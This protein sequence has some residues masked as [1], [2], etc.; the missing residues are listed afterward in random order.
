[1][2]EEPDGIQRKCMAWPFTR[3]IIAKA[4]EG[5]AGG[6]FFAN[7]TLH[8]ILTT[9]CWWPTMKKKVYSYRKQCDICQKIGPKVS[10]VQPMNPFIPTEVFQQ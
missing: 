9:L 10:R 7:H 5:V 2:K 3:A 6:H 1:M 4:H 8:K